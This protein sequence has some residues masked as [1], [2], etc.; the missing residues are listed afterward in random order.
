M[1]PEVRFVCD[2]RYRSIRDFSKVMRP[3][4][5]FYPNPFQRVVALLFYLWGD[6]SGR[7]QGI[8]PTHSET[9]LRLARQTGGAV[10]DVWK[11][12]TVALDTD[13]VPGANSYTRYSVSG[14]RFMKVDT[15]E[16]GMW[17]KIRVYD[18]SHWSHQHPNTEL[19]RLGGEA[20]EELGEKGVR[21]RLAEGF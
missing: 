10:W 1:P 21:C 18:L 14:S 9:L 17:A 2:S 8:Y 11:K 3:E 19:D 15:N 20:C 13:G 16:T 5:L 4:V 12:F 7:V 6:P